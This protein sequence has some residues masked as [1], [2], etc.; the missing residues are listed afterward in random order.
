M[1]PSKDT[2]TDTYKHAQTDTHILS[3]INIRTATLGVNLF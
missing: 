1:V 2:H 3:Q